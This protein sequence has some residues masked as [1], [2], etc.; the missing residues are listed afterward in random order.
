MRRLALVVVVSV[1]GGAPPLALVAV[2]QARD[3]RVQPTTGTASLSGI[4]VDDQN[5]AQP[6]RRAVVTL[7]GTGL[8]PNR[9]AITDDE[10]R[11]ALRDLP[12]GRF[13]LMAER[14][15]FVTSVYGARRPARP[16]TD[17]VVSNG[18]QITGV[19]LRLWRG[20]VLA[21]V[22]RDE[23]GDPLPN[24]PVEA[25]PIREVAPA[26]LTLSNNNRTL[27]AGICFGCTRTNDLGE[28]RM[29][30]LE[31]G[32]YL[33]RAVTQM[34]RPQVAASEADV[35][36]TL[37]ALVARAG[38]PGAISTPTARA[39]DTPPI[40]TAAPIYFP[41]TPVAAS[42][43]PVSLQAGEE[44]SGLDFVVRP[45]RVASVRGTVVNPSG[46]PVAGAFIRLSVVTGD[47]EYPGTAP[48]PVMA[49]AGADGAFVL[50]PI[51]PGD[52]T[53]LA[54][55]QL[56]S[57][58]GETGSSGPFGWTTV[59]IS[60]TGP[61]IDLSTLPLRPGLTFSGRVVFDGAA[62]APDLTTLRVQL[63]SAAL[64]PLPSGRRG[65]PGIPGVRFLQPSAVRADGAFEIADLVPDDYQL[66]VTGATLD[67]SIWWLRSATVNGRDLLDGPVRIAPG[68]HVRGVTVVLS[69]RRTELS[70]TITTATG[71]AASDLFVLVYPAEASM[72]VSGSRRIRAVRPDSDGRYVVGNL[73]PG[74]YLLCAVTDVDEGQWN[75]TGFL[76]P[77]VPASV[78]I[79][80]G[81]GERKVQDL[82]V[83][84]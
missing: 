66:A 48:A 26:G 72:R 38:R 75:E 39:Q 5:P 18:Q 53:L 43:T 6:V 34:G 31:P 9:G 56:S 60:V 79:T 42:A 13:T 78:R 12:P 45:V 54:R 80:L 82:R 76:D 55:G 24:T 70:G 7:T 14:G 27:V 58:R 15:G 59:P 28:F 1:V 29:F 17:I 47:V 22:V 67:A 25:I 40:V 36:A 84:G 10:G 4:V 44:R 50:S 37:A 2:E 19:R 83:G 32:T 77:L 63:Q 64:G 62:A 69:D 46:A 23:S 8:R 51:P 21:G 81:D 49:T 74:S 33:V 11:F 3:T 65:G 73:P 35:D 30:G 68:E 71:A 41:G 61:D 20:A 57:S 52:Y 16:G